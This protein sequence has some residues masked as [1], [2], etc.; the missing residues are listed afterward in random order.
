MIFKIGNP[1]KA[2]AFAKWSFW[3]KKQNSQNH[4][5]KDSLITL[6]LFCAKSHLRKHQILEKWDNYENRPS[7]KGYSLGKMVSLGQKLKL[8]KTWEKRFFN[9]I[10]G[11]LSKKALEK[12]PNIREMR[13]FWKS[14]IVPWQNG[15]FGS[16]WKLRN[17]CEKRF[18]NH[19]RVVLCKKPLEKTPNIPQMRR[20]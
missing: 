12:T 7:C 8:R 19:I 9:H 11:F 13:R 10:R 6:E 2:I 5:K 20:F 17:T 1:A 18:F 15:Q 14:A 3:V 4:A 16:K